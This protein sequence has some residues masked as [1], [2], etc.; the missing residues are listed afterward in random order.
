MHEAL[1]AR[2][3]NMTEFGHTGIIIKG[4][5]CLDSWGA[6]PFVISAVDRKWRFTDSDRFGPSLVKR[7]G[8]PLTNPWPPDRSPFWRLH[9]IWVRQG[10]RVADD[11]MSCIWDEPKPHLIQRLNKRNAVLVEAGE[12]DGKYIEV[13]AAQTQ[14]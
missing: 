3:W 1:I 10:R 6:G 2:V 8:D 7:N 14:D 5:G 12:E 9:R 4:F 11:R 13:D